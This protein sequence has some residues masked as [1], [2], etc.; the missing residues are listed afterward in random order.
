[1][2]YLKYLLALAKIPPFD[3]LNVG[4]EAAISLAFFTLA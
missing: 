1:M 2:N 4:V 3:C